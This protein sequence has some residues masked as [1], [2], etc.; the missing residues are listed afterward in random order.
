[1]ELVE[2]ILQSDMRLKHVTQGKLL[3]PSVGGLLVSGILPAKAERECE[4]SDTSTETLKFTRN[5][6]QLKCW[7]S[8]SLLACAK[9]SAFVTNFYLVIFR[10]TKYDK[11]NTGSSD[12]PHS[13]PD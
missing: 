10:L 5:P 11:D 4:L 2:L 3:G 9:P 12:T 13:L 6:R 8:P 1:M 7:L